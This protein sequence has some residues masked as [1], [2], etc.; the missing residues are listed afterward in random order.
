MGNFAIAINLLLET[1]MRK[2]LKIEVF[3][4]YF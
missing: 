2:G 1:K 4:R 3:E